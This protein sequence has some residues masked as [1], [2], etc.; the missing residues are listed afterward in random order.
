MGYTLSQR[1]SGLL[2]AH[3]VSDECIKTFLRCLFIIRLTILLRFS[4]STL[5]SMRV[6]SPVCGKEAAY[7]RIVLV[8]LL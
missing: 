3:T 1:A 8:S 5:M 4:V 6:M 7:R 2:P